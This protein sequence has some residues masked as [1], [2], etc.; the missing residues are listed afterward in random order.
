MIYPNLT[1]KWQENTLCK[2]K[3]RIE[4]LITNVMV[5]W[6]PLVSIILS[7]R[8]NHAAVFSVYL[9]TY[10]HIK[11][12]IILWLIPPINASHILIYLLQI[13]K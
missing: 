3:T 1:K 5:Q 10:I 11:W 13:I 9:L 12:L 2:G 6:R 4:R 8:R 7:D